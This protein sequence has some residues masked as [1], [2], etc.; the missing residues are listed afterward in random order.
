M[1]VYQREEP[2]VCVWEMQVCAPLGF[3]LGQISKISSYYA[4]P[5]QL[6]PCA[7]L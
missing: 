2:L 7:L 3:C 5:T 6:Q 1:C 4:K